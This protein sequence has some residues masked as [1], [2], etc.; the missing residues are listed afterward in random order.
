MQCAHVQL[1]MIEAQLTEATAALAAANAASEAAQDEL[2]SSQAARADLAAQLAQMR[3]HQVGST[4]PGT[5]KW[6]AQM[7]G[8]MNACGQMLTVIAL[9]LP[10][11]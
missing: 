7:D 8:W 11:Q 1:W 3:I 6:D 5:I 2:A 10:I 9:V 4:V